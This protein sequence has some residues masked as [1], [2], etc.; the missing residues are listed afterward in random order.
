MHLA[1]VPLACVL[2]AG[3]VSTQIGA[4]QPC[5]AITVVRDTLEHHRIT[6]DLFHV[7]RLWMRVEPG[8]EFHRWL[9]QASGGDIAIVLT[10]EPDSFGDMHDVR[11]LTGTLN[12]G[13]APRDT[14]VQHIICIRDALTG[15]VGPITFQT[16]DLATALLFDAYA[17]RRASIVMRITQS[18]PRRA[19]NGSRNP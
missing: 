3:H 13:T 9:S 14:S 12:H 8:T 7:H 2:L 5:N 1:L 16:D 19:V 6:N 10:T 15:S 11:I 18:G 17:G 4:H